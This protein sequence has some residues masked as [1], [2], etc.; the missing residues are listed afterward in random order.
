MLKF[1]CEKNCKMNSQLKCSELCTKESTIDSGKV[2]F[3]CK[4]K[5][6]NLSEEE[7]NFYNCS[8]WD[9]AIYDACKTCEL[10]CSQ[11]KNTNSIKLKQK[12]EALANTINSLKPILELGGS[13]TKLLDAAINDLK[14]KP[15][16]S[17]AQKNLDDVVQVANYAKDIL[18]SALLGRTVDIAQF[19]II[20]EHFEKKYKK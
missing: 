13:P 19:K 1:N 9:L 10:K 7:N 16:D 2:S 14:Q 3:S 18:N 8:L 6:K 4:E 15:M 5:L 17:N 20:K 11:N 12:S